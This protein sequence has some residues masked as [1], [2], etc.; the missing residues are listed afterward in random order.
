MYEEWE[1]AKYV[2]DIWSIYRILMKAFIL[3]CNTLFSLIF[4]LIVQFIY[5]ET[6]V[7]YI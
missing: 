5:Q 6:F 2:P 4:E 1:V 3:K 7:F